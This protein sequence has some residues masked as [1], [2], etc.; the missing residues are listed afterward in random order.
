[1]GERFKVKQVEE[2]FGAL[3]IYV[4]HHTDAIDER[5]AKAVKP[6]FVS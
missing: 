6:E 1:M 4:S 5:I 3:R 2:K